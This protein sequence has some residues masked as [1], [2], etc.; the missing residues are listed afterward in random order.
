MTI[1]QIKIRNIKGIS[2]K[3]FKVQLIPNKPN[4]LVA[5][6]G[7]GKSSIA[8]A[9]SSMNTKRIALD[10]KD[11]HME[12]EELEPELSIIING[13]TLT[14]DSSKNEI[15]KQFD[16]LVINS[17]LTPKAKKH[18]KGSVSSSLE[19]K[20]IT[21][22]KIPKKTEFSYKTTESKE[23]FGSNGKILPNISDLLKDF[24]LLEAI[25]DIDLSKFTQKRI[26]N[27]L[28]DFIENINQQKGTSA[29]ISQWILETHRVHLRAMPLLSQLGKRISELGLSNSKVEAF[30]SAYQIATIYSSSPKE[31]SAAVEWLNYESI[32]AHYQ[33]LLSNFKSSDWQWAK[34]EEIKTKKELV[35]TFPKAHQLSNGQRDLITLVTQ[36]HKTLYEGSRKPLILVIDEV[37]D[38]LDDANLVSFQYYVTSIIEAYKEQEQIIYPLILTH[39]DP[40]VFFDFCFNKH[41]I[42]INYLSSKPVGKSKNTLRL[43]E[44]RESQQFQDDVETI[45]EHLD[46][47]W[48]HFHP[49]SF[50]VS[51]ADWPNYLPTGWRNSKNFH[52]YTQAELTRYLDNKNYDPL[53]VCFAVRI[54]TEKLSYELLQEPAQRAKLID[55]V[56]KTKNKLNFVAATGTDIPE[57]YF[58]LGLIYNTNLHW[59]QDR[60][61][62]SPLTSKLNHPTIKHL[63]SDIKQDIEML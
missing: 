56:K 10:V 42:K 29:E 14:A 15:R 62:I 46:K 8:T 35:I 17:G 31:F 23:N 32:K 44:V 30:F 57:S 9:F 50:E 36:L 48:F 2:D 27:A 20:P 13:Q 41:K 60:D 5:Q 43:V 6:N 19:I 26:Q 24:R 58:L 25:R 49:D 59:N 3:S 47:H 16:V 11:H 55:K 12:D 21:I 61:Y 38:Y 63:I 7:F 52:E 45:K 1:S 54:I 18:F 4:L 28:S 22:S 33:D 34:V 53:A 51:E 39:L 37:F 40:G